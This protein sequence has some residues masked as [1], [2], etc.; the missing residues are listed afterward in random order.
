MPK[1]G[2]FPNSFRLRCPKCGGITIY[3][4]FGYDG[5]KG[6][7]QYCEDCKQFISEMVDGTLPHLVWIEESEL[8]ELK[9]AVQEA[10]DERYKR[11]VA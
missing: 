2:V 7:G 4:R 10:I 3:R 6:E 5:E 1:V 9:E 11:K 8:G